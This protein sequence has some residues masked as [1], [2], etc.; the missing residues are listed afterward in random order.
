MGLESTIAVIGSTNIDLVTYTAHGLNGFGGKGS[1]Q[2]AACAK[3]SR[4]RPNVADGAGTVK[5]VGGG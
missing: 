2:V 5:M 3:V 1:N 4:T